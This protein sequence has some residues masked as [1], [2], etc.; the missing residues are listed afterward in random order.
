M[1]HYKT[2]QETIRKV[3]VRV[4]DGADLPV[5]PGSKKL[6]RV[7]HVVLKFINTRSGWI[8]LEAQASGGMDLR[9]VDLKIC[10]HE[11]YFLCEERASFPECVEDLINAYLPS[12]SV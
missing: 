3:W 8:F 11:R 2:S 10:E 5:Y 6:F 9:S 7:E 12:D 1:K 4:H